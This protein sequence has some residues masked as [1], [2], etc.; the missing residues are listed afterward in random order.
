MRVD[1]T[2]VNGTHHEINFEASESM[3]DVRTWLN[4]A[5]SFVTIGNNIIINSKNII[6]IVEFDSKIFNDS[7]MSNDTNIE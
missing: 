2:M 7:N 6:Q 5:G 4:D 1:V 3:A